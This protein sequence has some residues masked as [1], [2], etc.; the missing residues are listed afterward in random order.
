MGW[1]RGRHP[2]PT[3]LRRASNPGADRLTLL[4][5]GIW[6]SVHSYLPKPP[7]VSTAICFK[8]SPGGIPSLNYESEYTMLKICL[9][10]GL[11]FAVAGAANAAC[12]SDDAMTKSADVAEVLSNKLSSN[13]DAASKLMTE[14]G[15]ITGNGTVTEATCTKLD[16]L[17]VRAKKL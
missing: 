9:A 2:A 11:L 16:D 10:V 6:F 1:N 15:T 7:L 5:D 3:P 13:M 12:S 8:T 17:M 4:Q 14:M